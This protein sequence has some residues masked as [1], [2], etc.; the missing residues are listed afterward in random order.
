[1]YFSSAEQTHFKECFW[2]VFVHTIKS[3]WGPKRT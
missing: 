1:M 2:T 3:R